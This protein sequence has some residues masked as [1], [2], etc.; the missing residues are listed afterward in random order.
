MCLTAWTVVREVRNSVSVVTE[1]RLRALRAREAAERGVG[2][3]RS[4]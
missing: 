2:L 3:P 1:Q 4:D